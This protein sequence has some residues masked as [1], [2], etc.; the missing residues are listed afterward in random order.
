METTR[1]LG[2][3]EGQ[4]Q[5]NLTEEEAR[6][7]IE[8]IRWPNGPAC[9]HCDS[10]RVYRMTG[11][12]IRPG[13]LACRDCNGQ[14]TVTV[15]TVMADSHLPL[16]TWVRAAHLIASSKKG[17][18]AAQL[19][20]NLGLGSYRTAWRLAH[21][22]RHAMACDPV[23]GLLQGAVQCDETYVDQKAR[24]GTGK[25]GRGTSKEPVV[26]IL[27]TE[28]NARSAPVERI[29]R[30][31]LR[32]AFQ[33]DV[34]P[35]ARIMSDELSAYPCVAAGIAGHERAKQGVG[36]YATSYGFNTNTFESYFSLP[37]RGAYGT[38]PH[39]SGNHL[40]RYS[41]ELW[42]R[43]SGRKIGDRERCGKTIRD[44]EHKRLPH[45]TL[46]GQR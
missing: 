5:P 30:E 23:A 19:Q 2:R 16:A 31:A 6:E 20:R 25:H 15:G 21:R 26:A 37:K 4:H 46:V 24:K 33:E 17:I 36:Q 44:I 1:Q 3:Q 13:L 45:Q 43:W 40:R 42:F 32:A 34:R 41:N 38:S 9:P 22:I 27:E 29:N 10:V 39:V 8:R 12:S 28:A 11:K 18:S 14:F 7:Y 35:S